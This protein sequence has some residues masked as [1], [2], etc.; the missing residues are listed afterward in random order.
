MPAGD[1]YI[2]EPWL[3]SSLSHSDPSS[4]RRPHHHNYTTTTPNRGV[5]KAVGL[6]T[7]TRFKRSSISGLYDKLNIKQA[8][9]TVY[10]SSSNF[11]DCYT[12]FCG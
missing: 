4:V 1:Y 7:E 12:G 3:H 5:A 10:A 6:S 11:N 9:S 2:Y 8:R